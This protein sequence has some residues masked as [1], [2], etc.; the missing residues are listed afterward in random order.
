[1][2]APPGLAR[3]ADTMTAEEIGRGSTLGSGEFHLLDQY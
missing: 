2:E 3:T 1:V